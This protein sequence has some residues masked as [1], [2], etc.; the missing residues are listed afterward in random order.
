MLDFMFVLIMQN[1]INK[2]VTNPK[3]TQKKYNEK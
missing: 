1:F 3:S 2:H